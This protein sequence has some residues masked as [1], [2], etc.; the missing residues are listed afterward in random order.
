MKS[1]FDTRKLTKEQLEVLNEEFVS[2]SNKKWNTVIKLASMV[3]EEDLTFVFKEHQ[4]N[5]WPVPIIRA[6]ARMKSVIYH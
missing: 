2:D 3:S 4:E 1:M 6:L 5:G